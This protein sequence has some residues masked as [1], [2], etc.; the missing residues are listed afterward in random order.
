MPIDR[1]ILDQQLQS[2][3]DAAR[4]WDQR[5]LRDLPGVLHPDEKLLAIARGKLARIRV[6]RRS[7]LIVVTDQRLLCLRSGGPTRWQQLEVNADEIERVSLRVGPL[8]GRV[9]VVAG[10]HTY[11]I[12]VPR[13]DSWK[14]SAALSSLCAQKQEYLSGRGPTLMVRRVFDHVLALPAVALDP[15]SP[16]VPAAAPPKENP[17]TEQRLQ[18]LEE[19]VQQLQQQVDF[20]EQLLRQRQAIEERVSAGE[21]T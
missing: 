10:S 3:G 2:L 5:E 4:W 16:R 17:E 21:L 1:G 6:V 18:L 19:Q 9:R 13:A 12:L 8:R 15:T 14:L 7:W 11:R 20:L